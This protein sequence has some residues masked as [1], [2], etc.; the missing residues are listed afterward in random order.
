MENS[1]GG[2]NYSER[3]MKAENEYIHMS[4][5]V[6]RDVFLA[7]FLFVLLMNYFCCAANSY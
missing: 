7:M 2:H 4:L 5:I 3:T 1:V 6:A